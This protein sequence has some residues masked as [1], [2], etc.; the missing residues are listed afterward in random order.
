MVTMVIGDTK[1]E[2]FDDLFDL[3]V[4]T[5]VLGRPVGRCNSTDDGCSN[6][7]TSVGCSRGCHSE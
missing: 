2:T 7:C 5:E 4:R 3:D 1:T 6:S